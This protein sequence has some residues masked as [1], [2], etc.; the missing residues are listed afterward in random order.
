VLER[1]QVVD[2]LFAS[3]LIICSPKKER[4]TFGVAQPDVIY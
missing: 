3:A 1:V 4:E 2:K